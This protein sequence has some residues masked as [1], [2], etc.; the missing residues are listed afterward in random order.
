VR[1]GEEHLSDA[2]AASAAAAAS[3][4]HGSGANSTAPAVQLAGSRATPR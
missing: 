4:P 3:K 1:R 2:I